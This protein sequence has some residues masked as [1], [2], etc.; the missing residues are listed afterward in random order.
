MLPQII[1][2]L[3]CPHDLFASSILLSVADSVPQAVLCPLLPACH[4]D[5]ERKRACALAIL[6]RMRRL[7]PALV[8]GTLQ[9]AENVLDVAA[10]AW[11]RWQA[12]IDSASRA[13]IKERAVDRTVEL[14]LPLHEAGARKPKSFYDFAF[15]AQYGAT[16]ANGLQLLESFKETQNEMCFNKAWDFYAQMFRTNKGFRPSFREV[17]LEDASPYLAELRDS[18]LAVPGTFE[19]GRPIITVQRL[20]KQIPIMASKQRPKKLAIVGSD[21]ITYQFLLKTNEDTRLDERAMQIFDFI[22]RSIASADIPLQTRL[23]ITTHKVV[24]L[25][26]KYGLIGWVTDC[27]TV[28]NLIVAYRTVKQMPI[29]AEKAAARAGNELSD[30]PHMA[31]LTAF[32]RNQ[33]TPAKR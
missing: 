11:E 22:S 21:G 14:L 20:M 12:A 18:P 15:L 27:E 17:D 16:L 30:D 28:A 13:F 9:F 4:T 2:R 7:C 32:E 26:A 1:A 10:T 8:D 29:H 3:G 6:E 19:H 25:T 31:K 23:Q 33:S 5:D 24:P